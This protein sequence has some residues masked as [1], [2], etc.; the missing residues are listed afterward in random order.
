MCK[1]ADGFLCFIKTDCTTGREKSD[2]CNSK[3][4]PVS[5]AGGESQKNAYSMYR[6]Q[7]NEYRHS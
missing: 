6:R 2:R 3:L 5:E 1:N 4:S 7:A